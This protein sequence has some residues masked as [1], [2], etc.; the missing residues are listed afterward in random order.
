MTER[1]KTGFVAA[2]IELA[3]RSI[4]TWPTWLQEATGV[5]ASNSDDDETGTKAQGDGPAN[6]YDRSE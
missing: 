1:A 5:R 3:Q 4:E 2:Q 6:Q